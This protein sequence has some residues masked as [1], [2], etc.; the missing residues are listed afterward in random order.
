MM[1]RRQRNKTDWKFWLGFPILILLWAALA[2]TMFSARIAP[3]IEDHYFRA[4]PEDAMYGIC[5]PLYNTVLLEQSFTYDE[6]IRGFSVILHNRDNL[7][8]RGR[9]ELTIS[10]ADTLNV[11]RQAS[12]ALDNIN[13]NVFLDFVFPSALPATPGAKYIIE[14]APVDLEP[15][16]ILSFYLASNK[17]LIKEPCVVSGVTQKAPL[18]ITVLG[19]FDGL[20]TFYWIFASVMLALALLVYGL[21]FGYKLKLHN[22][23]LLVAGVL[24]ALYMAVFLPFNTPDENTHFGNAYY[25]SSF[26]FDSSQKELWHYVTQ[27]Q[28]VDGNSFYYNLPARQGDQI[29]GNFGTRQFSYQDALLIQE[30][31]FDYTGSTDQTAKTMQVQASYISP[32]AYLPS[33]LGLVLGRLIGLGA[34]QL[35]LF[36]RLFNFLSYLFLCYFGIKLIPCHKQLLCTVALLPMAMQQAISYS[37]DNLALALVIFCIGYILYL[38]LE[39]PTVSLLD[40]LILLPCA[41]GLVYAKGIYFL[42]LFLCFTI[43]NN[44][45]KKP[46]LA[47]AGKILLCVLSVLSFVAI[48]SIVLFGSENVSGDKFSL[49][50]LFTAPG[51]ALWMFLQTLITQGDVLCYNLVGQSLGWLDVR[52]SGLYV[53]A[54][55]L[56]VLYSTIPA[57]DSPLLP[58]NARRLCGVTAFGIGFAVLAA[59]LMWTTFSYYE[60]Y[61][62]L[63]GLQGRYFL[64]ALPLAMLAIRWK[65]VSNQD[66]IGS[67]ALGAAFVLN[68]MVVLSSFCIIFTR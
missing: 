8:D 56:L 23:F 63:W 4:T 19:S 28:D 20:S 3:A 30:H 44:K 7:L 66:S 14:I 48:Y 47:L 21:V 26:V 31:L 35:V 52:L 34:V 43:P 6:S 67:G 41:I 27:K 57:H 58:T 33:I 45:F 16:A 55:S 53:L 39:K 13:E 42:V 61:N 38:A 51:E 15:T 10:D 2:F 32:I 64:P 25:Y 46:R 29:I 40:L 17:N 22:A 68:C 5:D 18:G 59:S 54:F 65:H 37:Y 9:L 50:L 1:R 62:M 60:K 24:G 11:L 49:N 12:V 36:G